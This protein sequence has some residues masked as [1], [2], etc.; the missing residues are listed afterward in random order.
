MDVSFTGKIFDCCYIKNLFGVTY[1]LKDWQQKMQERKE[2]TKKKIKIGKG[3]G[4][5]EVVREDGLLR[6]ARPALSS[7]FRVSVTACVSLPSVP[8]HFLTRGHH[9]TWI[10]NVCTRLADHRFYLDKSLLAMPMDVSKMRWQNWNSGWSRWYGR[11]VSTC[12][13]D[14]FIPHFKY[15]YG[16]SGA[17]CCYCF[18]FW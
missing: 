14:W 13:T 2:E 3:S 9:P 1:D 12:C 5:T 10:Q 11:Q 15:V 7:C 8:L 16:I 18:C 6:G 4:Y 17:F